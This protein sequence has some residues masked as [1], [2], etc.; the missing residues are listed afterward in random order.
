MQRSPYY[1]YGQDPNR[2]FPAPQTKQDTTISEEP[3][4]AMEEAYSRLFDMIK[5]T[6][7]YLIDLHNYP[8]G[9]LS[10][11]FR[12]PIYY[13]GGRDKAAAQQLQDQ[14]GEMLA[15]FGH[16]VIDE[17]ASADYLKMNLHRSVSGS[18]LNAARIPSFTAEL[19]GF[20]TVDPTMV[21]AA[22]A[23]IRNVMRWAGMLD[24]KPE[25][26]SGIK[27]LSS[28]YPIAAFNTRLRR[29]VGSSRSM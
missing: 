9:A 29:T 13:R 3:P 10:F 27:I 18:A 16:T 14:T 4:S 15:A 1:L 17:F 23:G 26:I 25:P 7:S 22:V 6:A 24:G 21:K 20:L 28:G 11:A 5:E 8:I 19:G 12:D 2:L